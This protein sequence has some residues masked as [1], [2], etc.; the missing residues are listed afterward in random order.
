[1]K[2]KLFVIS[3]ALLLAVSLSAAPP[4]NFMPNN[5]LKP[6]IIDNTSYINA[7]RIFMFVTNHGNFGRDLSGVFG[8]DYGTWFPYT[9]ISDIA[10]GIDK[11][12][13]YAGGLWVGAIDSAT[14]QIRMAVAIYSD[15]YVPGPM[16]NHTFEIDRPE[17]KV[18]KLFLDSLAGNPNQAYL[19]YL[20]Y[21]IAQGAPFKV[22]ES[23]DTIPDMKGDQ[24]CWS[25]YNDANPAQ[26]TNDAGL[27]DPLGVEVKGT[28]F[29]YDRQGSLGNIVFLRWRVYNK[30][31]NTLRNCYFSVWNDPDLGGSGDDVV[32]CDTIL[33]VGYIY[34][35]TNDDQY[36][37]AAPPCLGIDFFQGPLR[38]RT[39]ADTL[40]D[41]SPVPDGRMW[42][43]TYA[44]SVNLGMYSFAKYINGTDPNSAG[45][46]YNNMLGLIKDGSPYVYNG[47][48]LRYMHSGDPVAGTG[49]IDF[50]PA[51]R[52]MMLTTG[53]V[54]FRPGDSTEILAAMVIGQGSDRLNSI[55]VMK[56]L[57]NFAQRVY[58][59][60]FNPPK[61]PAKPKVTAAQ[62]HN[63]I[64]LSWTDTSEVDPGDYPF[65]GYTVWQ[66]PAASGPWRE[67]KTYD[68]VNDRTGALIDT[69]RDLYSGLDLPVVQRAIKN[70]G[71]VHSYTTTTDAILGGELKDITQYFFRIS[72]FS[73]SYFLP[74][75]SRVPAGDRFLESQT[76]VT[77]VPQAPVAG[78]H[79][80]LN[81]H[82][83]ILAT[84][85]TGLSDGSVT[86]FVIDPKA[87]TGH[88]Y[89]IVFKDTNFVTADG[90]TV[91]QAW[92]L[93]DL[94]ANKIVLRNQTN[95]SRNDN[96]LVVDG[97]MVKTA[98]PP[99]NFKSFEVVANS[100]GPL[101]PPEGG[102][103]DFGGFPS[104][105]PT[106][107]QQAGGGLW[108]IHTA[109][110]GGSCGGGTRCCFDA[111]YSRCTRD[112]ANFANIGTYDYEIRFTG[113]YDNPEVG[114]SYVDEWF[115]DD[116]VWWVPFEVWRIGIN[117]PD[118]ASDDVRLVPEII[119]DGDD[120]TFNLESWG[121]PTDPLRTGADG[122]HSVSGG[123][124]D[125]FTDWIYMRL[126][127]DMTPGEAG[128]QAN[129]AQMLA[130]AYDESLTSA[131]VLAR[132]VFVSWNG[133]T[134]SGDTLTNPPVFTQDLPE[135]GTI[136]RII[137]NKPNTVADTF[138]FTA[139]APTYTTNNVDL[140][141]ITAVPNPFYL[142]SSYDPNPG[143]NLM[144]FHHLP[145][146]CNIT[147]YNLAG[148]LIRTIRKDDPSPIATW[149]LVTE[150]GLPVASGI[151]IY[152]VDAPG[153]G[154][155]VGKVAVFVESEVLK[156][157]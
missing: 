23:G 115:N 84:H 116:N 127:T 10:A 79:P 11:S 155:K 39:A 1:M 142:Y 108:G 12:P 4:N 130:H 76:T 80:S 120:N 102:A 121:C 64:T 146:K 41:G 36:Y 133:H 25:V 22:T 124:N 29:A 30:G 16:V 46:S 3:I 134:A 106:A 141:K 83:S 110:N 125:P 138:T 86:A 53:P 13:Y 144:K 50:S 57:D 58:E 153:F 136:F 33:S 40:A 151:Y 67:L 47:D 140:D 105:R 70:T 149:D 85:A 8:Y 61:A 97:M 62:L 69:L 68:L 148:D 42:D 98:G 2:I 55:T 66:A 73:F 100:T 24:M 99:V 135:Q 14:N 139:P 117:T 81:A 56:D 114:G 95:Q 27:T 87:L 150:R 78:L 154:Q 32:G 101:D 65:E 90:D 111:F 123:D 75:G 35:Y 74:D 82:D 26:H 94:T 152:V 88:D 118:D 21:A 5:P 44:D 48:T 52:R 93:Y 38:A 119:D 54:T 7:N 131:E 19:E 132:V 129:E 6:A 128:Y 122:E 103:F 31:T 9:S 51:D 91:D 43:T 60:G 63:E 96:Y 156:I 28:V 112:G 107:R 137:T 15:E 143:S 145:T 72:A 17:F 71:L 49:D 113:S 89:R 147:I 18:Y 157:Y 20:Q 104:E 109:D 45:E 77:V 126:P 37:G 59:N 34:N 92:D